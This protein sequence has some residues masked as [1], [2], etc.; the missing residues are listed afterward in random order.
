MKN[1]KVPQ[2]E[3]DANGCWIWQWD[4]AK[5]GYGRIT[6]KG[7][8]MYAH[9]FMYELHNGPLDPDVELDHLC[10]NTLCV[11]PEHLE[12]VEHSENL[13]R[14]GNAKVSEKLVDGIRDLYVHGF[15]Q[16]KIADSLG[17][18]PSQ[19]SRI[20]TG[21]AWGRP[22]IGPGSRRPQKL[23]LEKARQIR[24][25]YQTTKTSTRKLAKQ[26]GVSSHTIAGILNGKY[27]KE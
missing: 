14:G 27:W 25:L 12:P 3:I 6:I 10:R 24:R 15:T 1:W 23:D 11:N 22:N 16:K 8:R 21:D 4:K 9:R 2:Y 7:K 26:F 19:I 5:H 17:M 13:R 20:I 18:H